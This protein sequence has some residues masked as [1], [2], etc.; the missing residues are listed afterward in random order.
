MANELVIPPDVKPDSGETVELVDDQTVSFRPQFGRAWSQ[1]N[2]FGDPRWRFQRRYR[3]LRMSDRARVL[4]ATSEAQGGFRTIM[5]SPAQEPRGTWVAQAGGEL[6]SNAD[7][8]NGTTGWNNAS[9]GSVS[10]SDGVAR[11]TATSAGISGFYQNYS[12][13]AGV[14]YA[15]RSVVLRGRG[16][17]SIPVTVSLDDS[18][19]N[20]AMTSDDGASGG[21]LVASGVPSTGGSGP[22]Y[23]ALFSTSSGMLA[24][25]YASVL[26]TSLSRCFLVDGGGNLLLQSDV[27]GTTWVP[28]NST[29]TSNTIAS[30]DGTG[31][32]D[33]I[34]EASTAT[35]QRYVE[36]T[37]TVSSSTADYSFS[38]DIK[39]G[40]RSWAYLWVYETATPANF[41]RSFFNL[42]SGAL[43]TLANGGAW[44]GA[45]AFIA[46]RGNGWYRVT[47]V[48]R[49]ST[50]ATGLTVRI[51]ATNADNTL[52]YSGTAATEA[53]Y[54]WRA[55]MSASGVPSIGAQ[56]TTT[57]AAASSQS[58]SGVP[59]KGLP[60]SQSGL[61]VAGD[62]VE[63]DGQLKRLT[64]PLN[65]DASGLG[66]LQVRPKIYRAVADN[67]PVIV[68]KPMGR[69][70]LTDKVSH[71]AMFGLY[72]D[73]DLTFDE[74]YE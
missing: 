21:Y 60:A 50:S 2:S 43:G 68:T 67:A 72:A 36:Q 22:T 32:G 46:S 17:S 48:V 12:S 63:I 65:S 6:L 26:F 11:L 49:K 70:V 23:P 20:I 54:Y 40:F 37:L 1:R 28:T 13:T 73:F 18:A 69:F 53:Q 66:Y 10:A 47:V 61:L 3:A 44:G 31:T 38:V 33:A 29:I 51:G 15:L 45:R 34:V 71:Q 59:V 4:L 19:T 35:E 30:P 56:T 55:S 27:F 9:Q 57:Q 16:F 14:P 25:D 74:V 7:F 42:F 64:A 62:W 58:G 41:G 5:V 8:S 24:G 39:A 52:S